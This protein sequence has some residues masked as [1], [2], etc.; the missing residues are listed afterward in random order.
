[1]KVGD[2]VRFKND[3]VCDCWNWD[4]KQG[5]W[6]HSKS[7]ITIATQSY[8]EGLFNYITSNSDLLFKGCSDCLE[9]IPI[10][11]FKVGDRVRF[12]DDLSCC[13]Q[14]EP[15]LHL[16]N[17]VK[18]ISSVNDNPELRPYR[19][20]SISGKKFTGCNNCLTLVGSS[21]EEVTVKELDLVELK[22]VSLKG[23]IE[24]LA[25]I[26][27]RIETDLGKVQAYIGSK[28]YND[29]VEDKV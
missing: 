12:T 5:W 3:P 29:I 18:S 23:Q 1:M 15:S 27:A 13:W 24:T 26:N 7:T 11:K 14:Q 19:C 28:L 20:V 21:A 10:L 22:I 6:E 8:R 25:K 17:E 4:S 9:V 16:K 2:K